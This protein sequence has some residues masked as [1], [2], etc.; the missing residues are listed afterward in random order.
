V[1]NIRNHD[2][3]L[4]N[5]KDKLK[6]SDD[7]TEEETQA[8]LDFELELRSQGIGKSKVLKYLSS[9]STLGDYIGFNLLN[10]NK[11]QLN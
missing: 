1:P 10:P 6:E 7:Y 3:R 4:Q 11:R 9:F 8:L 2:Q 5:I